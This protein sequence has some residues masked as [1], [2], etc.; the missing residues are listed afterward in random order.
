MKSRNRRK[1]VTRRGYLFRMFGGGGGNRRIGGR[2]VASVEE[3]EPT[4]PKKQGLRPRL[5]RL[6]KRALLATKIAALVAAMIG[7]GF[8][9]YH[10]YQ[11]ARASTYFNVDAIQIDGLRRA[12]GQK[13]RRLVLPAKGRNIFS[14]DVSGLANAISA[15]PWVSE[16]KVRRDLP[17]TLTVEIVEHK[18]RALMV[19]GNLYL[20][21]ARGQ[22]FKRTQ[23][24]EAEGL[25]TITGISRSAF[26]KAPRLA[27]LRLK[28]ALAAIDSY[29]GKS[30]P[31]IS[32][33]HLGAQDELTFFLRKGGAAL[34][35]G[36]RFGDERLQKLDVIWASLG[37]KRQSLRAVYLD[38]EVRPERVVVRVGASFSN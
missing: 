32:E 33:V 25:P 9:G 2:P 23:I 6:G 12:S 7:A 13:I 26:R 20:V 5:K 1:R 17:R 29:Y 21:N 36:R 22:V 19:L 14:V 30:R 31:P 10:L 15:Q 35:F 24:E 34:R 18:A 8:G 16:A 38:N 4:S 11:R 3:K 27:E 37:K 28:R